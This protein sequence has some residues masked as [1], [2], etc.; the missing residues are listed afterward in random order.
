MLVGSAAL[1]QCRGDKEFWPR[2]LVVGHLCGCGVRMALASQPD[3]QV[4]WQGFSHSCRAFLILQAEGLVEFG[5]LSPG[6]TCLPVL[7]KCPVSQTAAGPKSGISGWT[8]PRG[9]LETGRDVW[10]AVK[11][12]TYGTSLGVFLGVYDN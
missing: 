6:L 2:R 10:L 11:L 1:Q 4:A 3:L 7:H 9:R 12:C 8:D 5:S